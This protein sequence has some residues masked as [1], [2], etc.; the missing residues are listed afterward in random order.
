MQLQQYV[1][2]TSLQRLFYPE[3]YNDPYY[4]QRI[5]KT[6]L[7]FIVYLPLMDEEQLLEALRRIEGNTFNR[8]SYVLDKISD[9]YQHIPDS[10]AKKYADYQ[11]A[12][13]TFD[14]FKEYYSGGLKEADKI[15]FDPQKSK[16]M[17]E[18][19]DE[20]VA[21]IERKIKRAEAARTLQ[22]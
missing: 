12:K 10:D 22:E 20:Y 3:P 2:Q 11:A 7:Q 1:S 18:Y 17:L 16:E 21:Y 19:H 5:I 13:C 14:Y 9:V 15:W 4:N 8:E 6:L